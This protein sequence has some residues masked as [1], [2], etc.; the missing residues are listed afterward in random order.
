MEKDE[1]LMAVLLSEPAPAAAGDAAKHAAAERDMAEVRDQLHRIGDGLARVAAGPPEKPVR[2]RRRRGLLVLAA[3]VALA[4]LGTGGSYLAARVGSPDDGGAEARLTEQALLA[5]STAIA[6][7]VVAKVE[8]LGGEDRFRI[9]LDVEHTYK[10][11]TG[12]ARLAFTAE[13]AETRTYY[14]I[15][16]RMLVVVSR[17][18]EE[19][20]QTYRA[21]DPAP[22]EGESDRARDALDWGREW[23]RGT[24][25]VVRGEKC[26]GV[27]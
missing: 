27:G 24:L 23:I 2:R 17:F 26:P 3:S 18:P 8:P 25:P 19:G 13:G 9:V 6:E 4:V 12:E 21:G 14:R 5:C 1:Y 22:Q 10:P 15:G 20:P 7:G 11:G 16:A